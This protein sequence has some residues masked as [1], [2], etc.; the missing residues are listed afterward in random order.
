MA[1]Q[2]E[3]QT[4]APK[5]EK[6]IRPE[7]QLVTEQVSFA[8]PNS[9]MIGMPLPPPPGTPNSVMREMLSDAQIGA[10]ESEADQLSAGITSGTPNSVRREMGSRL[11][12]DFSSIHFHSNSQSILQ[13]ESMGSRAYTRGN[14]VYFGR[15]GFNP[16][17]AAHELVHTVQQGAV[18]GRVSQS[19]SFGTVQMWK[20]FR[21]KN[22]EPD[23][24]DALDPNL[25]Q[26][27][28][29]A[30]DRAADI[31]PAPVPVRHEVRPPVPAVDPAVHVRAAVH[32]GVRG[33]AGRRAQPRKTQEELQDILGQIQRY[34]PTKQRELT[35]MLGAVQPLQQV[36]Q[37]PGKLRQMLAGDPQKLQQLLGSQMH[38]E[39]EKLKSQRSGLDQLNTPREIRQLYSDDNERRIGRLEALQ[40][41][42]QQNQNL[43]LSQEINDL[44]D[45]IQ[46]ILYEVQHLQQ[47]HNLQEGSVDA[48]YQRAKTVQNRMRQL[49]T[50]DIPK[51]LALHHDNQDYLNRLQ[52][53]L[54]DPKSV[55]KLDANGVGQNRWRMSS[56]T[57]DIDGMTKYY[58]AWCDMHGRDRGAQG[59]I[60]APVQGGLA[61]AQAAVIQ[62][63]QAGAAAPGGVAPGP[64]TD[65]SNGFHARSD[66]V[67]GHKRR[68]GTADAFRNAGN[69]VNAGG[70]FGVLMDHD[71]HHGPIDGKNP[72]TGEPYSRWDLVHS[73]GDYSSY[74]DYV[75]PV[76]GGILGTYGGVTATLNAATQAHDT[77]RK[78]QNVKIGGSRAD[79]AESGLD[80]FASLAS[81]ASGFW[82]A[83]NS[84]ASIGGPAADLGG[85]A[86]GVPVLSGGAGLINA[87]SGG[88]ESEL[89]RRAEKKV[90]S[91]SDQLAQ[92]SYGAPAPAASGGVKSDQQQL[93][94]AIQHTRM[95][96]HLHQRSGALK[97]AAGSAQ[98]AATVATLAGGAPVA[99]AFQGAAAIMSIAKVA[100]DRGYKWYMRRKVV[101]TYYN[102]NWSDE[103]GKEHTSELQSRI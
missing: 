44:R 76:A 66:T 57:V 25:V 71:I 89:A 74:T 40:E 10:A 24:V 52:T 53:D 43:Q 5:Q 97:A 78:A 69:L 4:E 77:Y 41:F 94:E 46:D 84:F 73:R 60:M 14:N 23:P 56:D 95:V 81:G 32:P 80:A 30:A 39:T 36:L 7:E 45:E 93:E 11:G 67:E 42:R 2:S 15:G 48:L 27:P 61:A 38:H 85:A 1:N 19:V 51:A 16:T 65:G 99:A 90:D 6:E 88:M 55:F 9:T 3:K 34:L 86:I 8:L 22:R 17:V 21:K 18:P 92:L 82:N 87:I 58:I 29:Q 96:T 68:L 101:G 12:A 98:V 100:F 75:A 49:R 70:K 83:V 103:I 13:N 26:Q 54:P 47:A 79:A 64:Q 28:D 91:A 20:L 31:P 50:S 33:A 72:K 59:D 102:I 37:E 62:R 35:Q 63:N